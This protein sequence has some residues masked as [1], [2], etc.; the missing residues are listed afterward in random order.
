MSL[1]K[2]KSSSVPWFGL[3]GLA[4]VLGVF[5]LSGVAQEIAMFVALFGFLAACIRAI[6]LAVR[7]N[8]VSSASIRDPVART[9]GIVGSDSSAAR[10]RRPARKR[11]E[12]A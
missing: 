11:R 5:V 6:V 12:D 8:E 2:L 7:D 3:A 9:M 4:F 10:R 1:G